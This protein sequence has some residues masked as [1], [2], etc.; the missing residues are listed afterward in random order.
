MMKKVSITYHAAKG[1]SK[2]N[3]VA[4]MVFYDGKAE[5]VTISDQLYGELKNNRFFEIGK[6][7]D[8]TDQD[9]EAEKQKAEKAAEK[10]A[11]KK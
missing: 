8:V 5:T 7:T 9:A 6:P 2:V 3:E 4:G 11:D 10:P 1:D